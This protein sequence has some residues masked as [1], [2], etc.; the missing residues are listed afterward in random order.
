MLNR[1]TTV[2]VSLETLDALIEMQSEL[3]KV[4]SPRVKVLLS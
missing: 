4:E 3:E 2:E 1:N